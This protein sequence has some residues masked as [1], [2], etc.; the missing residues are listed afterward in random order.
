MKTFSIAGTYTDLYQLTVDLICL[1]D[2]NEPERMHHPWQPDKS[3]NLIG[4][5]KEAL[6]HKALV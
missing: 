5:K 3:I 6:F 1:T 4:M 2:E